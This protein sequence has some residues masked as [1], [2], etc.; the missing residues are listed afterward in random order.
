[1]VSIVLIT[2]G[3]KSGETRE[4]RLYAYLDGDAL[5]IVASDNGKPQEPHWA[6]NLR[7]DPRAQVRRGRAGRS[8]PVRARELPDGPERD[9]L[10]ALAVEGFHYYERMQQRSTRR[11]AVFR[12]E[13]DGEAEAAT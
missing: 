6:G 7:A 2:T 1:M 5:V 12:L 10:W 8:Q 11:F 9:R 13:P 3:R 4:A